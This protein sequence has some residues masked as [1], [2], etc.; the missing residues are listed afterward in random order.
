MGT[1]FGPLV[2]LLVA[3]DA[4]SLVGSAGSSF[5]EVSV[6]APNVSPAGLSSRGRGEGLLM[7]SRYAGFRVPGACG[8]HRGRGGASWQRGE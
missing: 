8:A 3:S 5:T 6:S 1:A 7:T 2:D 4:L